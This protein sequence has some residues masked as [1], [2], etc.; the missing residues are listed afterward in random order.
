MRGVSKGDVLVVDLRVSAGR[1]QSGVRPAIAVAG[2]ELPGVVV[3]V[4]LT[5]AVEALRFSNT[6]AILPD[7][8]NGLEQESVA[9]IFHV[10]SIDK[11]RIIRVIGKIDVGTKKKI[12]AA[13][14]KIFRLS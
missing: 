9:L 13:L 2:S 6:L 8:D 5:G 12:D 11:R 14:K 1:E 4:P 10:K 7:K 3:V